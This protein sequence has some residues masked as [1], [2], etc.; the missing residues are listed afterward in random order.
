MRLRPGIVDD[1]LGPRAAA[2]RTLLLHVPEDPV[3]V[4]Q[5]GHEIGQ[6]VAV[7]VLHVN[8]SGRSKIEFLMKGPLAIS[9][10]GRGFEP[11]LGSNDVG[12][13]VAVHVARAD[14]VTVAVRADDV[15][16]PLG[17]GAAA[18]D[19]VPG[20]RKI[21]VAKLGEQLGRLPG[22]QQ[23]DEESKLHR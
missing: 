14:A 8:E 19:L 3:V 1:V 18:G 15:S 13:A 17:V 5:T 2:I 11:A 20:E 10:V 9:R 23:V 21:L 22:V 12:A 6:P 16:R 7:H 4:S